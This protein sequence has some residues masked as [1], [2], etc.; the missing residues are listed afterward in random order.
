MILC[1]EKELER[2]KIRGG[3]LFCSCELEARLKLIKFADGPAERWGCLICI[4][5][6]RLRVEEKVG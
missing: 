3:E 1:W 2:I 5:R 6:M 4:C